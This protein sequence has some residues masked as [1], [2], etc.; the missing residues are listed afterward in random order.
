[1]TK[2]RKRPVGGS[3]RAVPVS[4]S[5][6]AKQFDAYCKQAQRESLSLPEL[7]RRLLKK[8]S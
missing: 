2:P 1:M 6:P 3:A 8:T 7:I 4:I 5:L